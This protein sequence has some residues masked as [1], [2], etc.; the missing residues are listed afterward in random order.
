MTR[1]TRVPTLAALA[2]LLAPALAAAAPSALVLTGNL[3]D[4]AGLM[5]RSSSAPITVRIDGF[6]SDE[7][8]AGLAAI[9]QK[10]G[11]KG[12][13]RALFRERVG[14]FQLNN[15]IGYPIAFARELR[16]ET[17]RHL[18]LVVRRT[19]SPREIWTA[20]RSVD[21]PFTVLDIDLDHRG[22]GSGDYLPAARLR[23]H[24]DGRVEMDNLTVLPLR[25]LA[26]RESRP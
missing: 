4:S 25:L 20:A 15:S 1:R 13:S 26:L 18:L 24:E 5:P 9:V 10:E 3:V 12:L 17:G 7:T 2:A 23:V 16:D 6:T 21:Y 14:T 22:Q 8:V 19:L 11:S